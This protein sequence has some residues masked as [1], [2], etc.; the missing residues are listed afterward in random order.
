MAYLAGTANQGLYSRPIALPRLSLETG[1]G[2][3]DLIMDVAAGKLP[4]AS[5]PAQE[6]FYKAYNVSYWTMPQADA[7]NWLNN[8]FGTSIP[9]P[10]AE[11]GLR[12][13]LGPG[14]PGPAGRGR[15]PPD[16]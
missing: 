9:A 12:L 16:G 15:G 2:R 6:Q 8:Q 13:P 5:T 10:A 4:M 14:S 3:N 1:Q 7:A 11:A